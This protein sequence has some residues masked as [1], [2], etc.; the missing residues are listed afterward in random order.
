MPKIP[1]PPSKLQLRYS[2]LEQLVAGQLDVHPD[3]VSTLGARMR[4]FRTR[5]FPPN[6]IA[7]TKTQ[8]VYDLEAVLRMTLAFSLIDAFVPQETV[9][10]LIERDWKQL[11]EAYA[12]AYSL[13]RDKGD[14]V[15]RV[16]DDRPVLLV[17]PRNL[18]AFTLEKGEKGD[19]G[20]SV[21]MA[22][23]TS[24][25]ASRRVTGGANEEDY[26][27]IMVVDIHRLAA[28]VRNAILQRSWAGPEAFDE[29]LGD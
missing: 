29:L 5:G 28:W 4:L 6:V 24:A 20:Q 27:P 15:A 19:P 14:D 22:V 9:P 2:Q 18:N 23:A 8:F 1:P 26:A 25:D 17:S 11:K 16:D 7:L 21:R 3:R 12:K 10:L 13:I